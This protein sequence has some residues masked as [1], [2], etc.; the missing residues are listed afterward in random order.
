MRRIGTREFPTVDALYGSQDHLEGAK[1]FAER[2]RPVWK[3]YWT[4]G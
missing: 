2:R 3:G 4:S 1:A